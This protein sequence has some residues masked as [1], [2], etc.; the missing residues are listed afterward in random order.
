M[1]TGNKIIVKTVKD[2]IYIPIECVQAGIDSIPFVYTKKGVKQVVILGESNE[3][4][5]LIEKGLEAGTLLYISNPENPEKFKMDGKELIP[6]IRARDKD[7]NKTAKVFRKE[8]DK[9]L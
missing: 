9:I 7:R 6:I 5:I 2:A 4:Y 1:T 3:K 8:P